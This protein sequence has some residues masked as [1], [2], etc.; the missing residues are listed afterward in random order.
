MGTFAKLMACGRQ[1]ELRASRLLWL[2]CIEGSLGQFSQFALHA[3]FWNLKPFKLVVSKF[4]FNRFCLHHPRMKLQ[5]Y[6][7][8]HMTMTN[9]DKWLAKAMSG[10]TCILILNLQTLMQWGL[11]QIEGLLYL[12]LKP[13]QSLGAEFHWLDATPDGPG[14]SK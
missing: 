8:G 12:I 1:G 9:P 7:S 4:N 10:L 14:P 6:T 13:F 3:A 5:S 11:S 2:A